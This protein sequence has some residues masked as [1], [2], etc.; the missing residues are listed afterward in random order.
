MLRRELLGSRVHVEVLLERRALDESIRRQTKPDCRSMDKARR[1]VELTVR[2][3]VHVRTEGND[4]VRPP[5]FSMMVPF[6]LLEGKQPAITGAEQVMSSIL[7]HR[8]SGGEERRRRVMI[9]RYH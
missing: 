5:A 1:Q 3:A 9:P 7:A 4:L 6:L 2:C 8:G